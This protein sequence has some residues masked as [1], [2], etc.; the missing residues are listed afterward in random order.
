[1][2]VSETEEA[3]N[4]RNPKFSTQ[5]KF[6]LNQPEKVV[7][8]HFWDEDDEGEFPCIGYVQTTVKALLWHAKEEQIFS[9]RIKVGHPSDYRY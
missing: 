9:Q 1:M 8:F 7:R 5:L 6:D 3:R 2:I 4:T